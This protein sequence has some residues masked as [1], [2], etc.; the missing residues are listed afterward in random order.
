MEQLYRGRSSVGKQGF[1]SFLPSRLRFALVRKCVFVPCSCR[2]A[3][4]SESRV[5]I[6]VWGEGCDTPGVT[7]A[8]TVLYSVSLYTV[9]A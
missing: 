6:S 1:P 5:E 7:V 4:P 2:A 3:T 8:A 9:E